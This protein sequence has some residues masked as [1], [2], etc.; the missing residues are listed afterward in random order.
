MKILLLGKNGQVGNALQHTLLTCGELVAFSR[1]D[2][3]LVDLEALQ[4]ILKIHT[5]DIIVNAAAYTAVDRAEKEKQLA[6][7]INTKAVEVMAHYAYRHHCLLVHYSSDY[8][9]DGKKST[10]YIETDKSRP[11]NL[12]GYSKRAGEVAIINSACRA[13]IFRT[14]WV[15]SARGNN[16]IKTIFN[17]AQARE[18]LTVVEDQYG[19]PTSA[20]FI[21]NITALCIQRYLASSLKL[22][23]YHL[24]AAGRTSWYDLAY[25]VLNQAQAHGAALKVNAQDIQ[26]IAAKAYPTAA[27]RPKNSS[28]NTDKLCQQLNLENLPHWTEQVED[29]VQKLVLLN[30]EALS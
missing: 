28:L 20:T 29:V 30:S 10:S 15:F 27:R 23:I 1:A 4:S 6:Y 19:A 7:Q 21:A 17:L 18:H 25:F 3:D 14:S 5:P 22:G 11:L 24:T 16:F 26:P 9:F 8:I 2:I 13:L 12:Y